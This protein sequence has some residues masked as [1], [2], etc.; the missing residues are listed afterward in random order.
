[1]KYVKVAFIG[2]GKIAEQHIK[3]FKA[4]KRAK[5]VGIYSRTNQKA[6]ILKKK[7]K[8]FEVC[9]NIRELY[10]KNK[11]DLVIVAVSIIN[12]KKIIE[13]VIKY[14]WYCLCEKPLGL[15]Y[16]ETL[17]LS[18]KIKN[19][20]NFFIAFNRRHYPSTRIALDLLNYD[21]SK[22][23]IFINDQQDIEFA[24]KIHPNR[25]VKNFMYANSIHLVDYCNIFARGKPISIKKLKFFSEN[26]Y[27]FLSKEIN[28]SSGDKVIFNS[29]WNRPGPWYV[30]IIAKNTFVNL[31]PLEKI[32]FKSE[33]QHFLEKKY[34]KLLLKKDSFKPGFYHQALLTIDSILLKK[35][36][37]PD[38]KVAFQ[39][40][41][42]TKKIFKE[43]LN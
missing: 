24:K 39:T 15:D 25:V 23:L 18:K 34:K 7:Y 35:M 19:K 9:K 20:K 11:P 36:L 3:V 28:Y 32:N 8:I 33:N 12:T 38:F 16:Y 10:E 31:E 43:M 21:K 37:V 29:I 17:E 4:I 5:L 42:L 40:T 22:R 1:M 41:I 6:E 13:E 14:K 26:K 27:K 30:K 2:A